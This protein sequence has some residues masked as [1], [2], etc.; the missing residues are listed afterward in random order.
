MATTKIR[1]TFDALEI[2]K[3]LQLIASL[4]LY[5]AVGTDGAGAIGNGGTAGRLRT[6]ATTLFRIAGRVYSK[7]STDDLWNLTA[8]TNLGAGQ[9]QAH[10]L[11]LDSSGT[12]TIGSGTVAT[13]AAAALAAL[14][15]LD[16][17]KAVAGV[18]VAGPSTDYD[19]ALAA[20]GTIYDGIPEGVRLIGLP[21]LRYV[22]PAVIEAVAA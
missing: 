5:L 21:E 13:S 11:Y 16:G 6:T 12:A 14:P 7:A 17:T 9:Y 4:S 3:H 1:R 2:D 8:V 22:K 20:Q 15:A 18:Y 19:A 10:W